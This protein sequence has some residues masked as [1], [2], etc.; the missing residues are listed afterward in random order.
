VASDG[1]VFNHGN[2]PFL[3]SMGGVKLNQPV[4][5]LAT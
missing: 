4:V 1:G 3:G 5:A 2:A